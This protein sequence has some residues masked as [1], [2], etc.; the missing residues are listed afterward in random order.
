[1]L[2]RPWW[3][4]SKG[5]KETTPQESGNGNIDISDYMGHFDLTFL[6]KL[7]SLEFYFVGRQNLN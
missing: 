5:S 3:K 2:F 7:G 1:M 4:I 6:Y